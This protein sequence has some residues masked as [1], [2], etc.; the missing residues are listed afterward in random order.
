M[1]NTLKRWLFRLLVLGT[2]AGLILLARDQLRD[3]QVEVDRFTQRVRLVELPPPP[4]PKKIELPPPEVMVKEEDK[5]EPPDP[6][7]TIDDQQTMDDRLGVDAEGAGAG[8]AFGLAAKK[9]GKDL[10]A[11]AK[12]GGDGGQGFRYYATQIERFLERALAGDMQLRRGSY[13]AIVW[14]WVGPSGSLERY[15]LTGSSGDAVIDARLREALAALRDLG[16]PP[17]RDMPQPVRLRVSS[18]E[19][20]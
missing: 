18:R 8:D 20:G 6:A 1:S 5:S 15:E 11:T 17:P 12:I 7:D 9:G 13:S 10:L 2:V 19:A 4:P 16:L 14:L 3:G